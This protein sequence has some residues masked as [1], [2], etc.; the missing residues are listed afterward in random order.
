M[1]LMTFRDRI[2]AGIIASG[3]AIAVLGPCEPRRI[4]SVCADRLGIEWSV[5]EGATESLDAFRN[6]VLDARGR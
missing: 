1:P 2:I 6:C 3:L 4:E 5:E